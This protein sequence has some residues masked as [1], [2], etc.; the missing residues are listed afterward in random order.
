MKTAKLLL[1]PALLVLLVGGCELLV[2]FKPEGGV[3]SELENLRRG[4][5]LLTRMEADSTFERG[6]I[7]LVF[8]DWP[9]RTAN[10]REYAMGIKLFCAG[11]GG[12]YEIVDKSHIRLGFVGIED[13]LCGEREEAL[14]DL[15]L[16]RMEAS[17]RYY[18]VR[19]KLVLYEQGAPRQRLVFEREKTASG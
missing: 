10:D 5:W 2:S 1:L 9:A 17:D 3:P 7:Y 8:K 15:F 11:A 19:D 6:E 13:I 16:E 18:I 14:T 4:R 12:V